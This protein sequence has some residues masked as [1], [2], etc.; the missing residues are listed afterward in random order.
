M[1]VARDQVRERKVKAEEA[2][3]AGKDAAKRARGDL[4]ERVA[5]SKAAYK[6]ALAESTEDA[7]A[8]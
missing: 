8:S 3:Q 5:E 2:L 7:E 6:A 4:E 1:E